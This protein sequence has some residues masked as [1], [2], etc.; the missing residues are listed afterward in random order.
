M[1]LNQ[2]FIRLGNELVL[3][4]SNDDTEV[5]VYDPNIHSVLQSLSVRIPG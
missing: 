2:T 4:G 1:D 5:H 3:F